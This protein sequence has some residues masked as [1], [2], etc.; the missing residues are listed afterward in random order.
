VQKK[1][2]ECE[3]EDFREDIHE[4]GMVKL[5]VGLKWLCFKAKHDSGIYN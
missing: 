2:G 5:A 4:K 3:M 1:I